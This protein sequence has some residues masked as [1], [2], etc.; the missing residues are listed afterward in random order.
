MCIIPP[1]VSHWDVGYD[2]FRDRRRFDA[3]FVENDTLHPSAELLSIAHGLGGFDVVAISLVLHQL[4]WDEQV[5]ALKQ[6][7]GLTG[8][9][10]MV[11]GF[12]VGNV[13]A[14]LQPNTNY[15]GKSQ[16]WH[17]FEGFQGLWGQ[18][19]VETGTKWEC[20]VVWKT[21]EQCEYAQTD[22]AY[23]GENARMMGWVARRKE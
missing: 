7:V 4:D 12:Q 1:I 13:P 14:K 6:V 2:L 5:V 15:G 8:V 23:L 11:V 18:I 9:R 17:D 22:I 19:G 21:W 16:L 20:E 3:Q 10:G